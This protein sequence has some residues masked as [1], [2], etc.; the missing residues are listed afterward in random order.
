VHAKDTRIDRHLAAMNGLIETAPAEQVSSR[1]W[2]YVT[3]GD[4][5]GSAWWQRFV[6]A[7]RQAGYDDMLSI[8]HEGFGLR[9][10][11]GVTRSVTLL[12]RVLGEAD[13][14]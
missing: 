8:E 1:S 14:H 12:R 11:D 13:R 6:Q 9:P 3:L 5:H 10:E 4:G 7:L 2:S